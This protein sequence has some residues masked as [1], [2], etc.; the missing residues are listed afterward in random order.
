[1]LQALG[2][3]G[4]VGVKPVER[5]LSR[6]QGRRELVAG[7]G[8]RIGDRPFHADSESGQ[9]DRKAGDGEALVNS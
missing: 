1:M 7:D 2:L 6:A 8:L 5:V 3:S 4:L 9:T